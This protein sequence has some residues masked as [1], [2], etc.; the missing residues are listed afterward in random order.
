MGY[1][2]SFAQP[3]SLDPSFDAG[4]GTDDGIYTTSIQSDGKIIFG[5]TF[6]SYNGTAR[7]N[8]ARL[9]PDGSLDTSFDPGTGASDPVYTISIQRDGKIIFGG[10]FTSFNGTTRNSIA[11]LEG[12]P[13]G[14]K[15]PVNGNKKIDIYPNPF[16]NTA[17]LHVEME[18][19]NAVLTVTNSLGQPVKHLTPINIGDGN[20][21]I[22]KRDI[23][24]AG[25]YFIQLSQ[26]N[27]IIMTEKLVITD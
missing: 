17:T 22:L 4:T 25:L 11:R 19:K 2:L 21:F 7:N 27:Q 15:Q 26:D 8:I 23:L 18:L 5:G 24:P 20:T 10:E 12:T 9:N 3:G 13:V 16:S 1:K 14:I 6:T